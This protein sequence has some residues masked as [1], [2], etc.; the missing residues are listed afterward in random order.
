MRVY[1]AIH[2]YAPHIPLFEKRIGIDDR[3]DITFVEL[4]KLIIKDGF[5]SSYILQPAI[6][7]KTDEVFFTI[8]DYERLQYL[9]ADEHGMQSRDLSVIK[10]A[11]IDWFQPDV[12]YNHSAFCDNGFIEKFELDEKI[13]KVC[14]FAFIKMK[15]LFLPGYDIRVSLH[16]PFIEYWRNRDLVAYEL[17]PSFVDSWSEFSQ[18]R[19]KLT[20]CSMDRQHHFTFTKEIACSMKC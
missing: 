15:P 7:G 19:K 8:W 2:K 4:Q 5:A 13:I 18:K 20:C 12:F 9:W 10:K 16:R 11:Q 3:T 17:Q 1:Q 6:Q 14:W